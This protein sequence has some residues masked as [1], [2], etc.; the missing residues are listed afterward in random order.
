MIYQ[1]L[2]YIVFYLLV[3]VALVAFRTSFFARAIIELFLVYLIFI[4]P[5]YG[6]I[7]TYRGKE[8]NYLYDWAFT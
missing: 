4:L 7:Q 1:I 5:T 3:L 2:F 8:F 6:A